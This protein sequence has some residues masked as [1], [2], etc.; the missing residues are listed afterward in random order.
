MTCSKC[1]GFI[2]VFADSVLARSKAKHMCHHCKLA[3]H[4]QT[5]E[6]TS[7]QFF[8]K[9]EANWRNIKDRNQ[10]TFPPRQILK[11]SQT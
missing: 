11:E 6:S 2:L 5:S 1:F 10:I 4:E 7:H 8:N 9:E 3:A